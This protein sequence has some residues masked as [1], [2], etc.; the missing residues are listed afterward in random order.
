MSAMFKYL[1]S[2][3]RPITP[4]FAA[5]WASMEGSPTERDVD[6]KRVTYLHGQIMAGEAIPFNWADAVLKGKKYRVNGQH[7]SLVLSKLNGTM[8]PDLVVHLDHYEVETRD[9]L[10]EL[11]RKFDPRQSSRTVLDVSGAYQGL[12]EELAN[13]PKRIAKLALEGILWRDRHVLGLSPPKND[14]RFSR[15][16]KI[17]DHPFIK[18]A[19][20]IITVKTPELKKTSVLAA[21]YATF[22]VKDA[23]T[24]AREFWDIAAKADESDDNGNA[25]QVLDRWLRDLIEVGYPDGV[26]HAQIYQACIFC[27]N[28]YREGRDIAKV[29][30]DTKRGFFDPL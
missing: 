20:Q 3:T 16:N 12:V 8:P 14:D 26:R 2:E 23:E 29:R 18:W 17:E 22:M 28:A 11:F 1:G 5:E 7:S 4:Q 6:K 10:A 30:F 15:F 27:W 9:G 24:M 19:G 21:M 13:T 25:A